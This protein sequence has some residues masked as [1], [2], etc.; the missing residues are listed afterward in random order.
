MK[1]IHVSL[2]PPCRAAGSGKYPTKARRRGIEFSPTSK[3][4]GRR[5]VHGAEPAARPTHKELVKAR[6]ATNGS[7]ST[8]C[9]YPIRGIDLVGRA[10]RVCGAVTYEEAKRWLKKIGGEMIEGKEQMR[11]TGSIVV[12]VKSARGQ[13]VQRRALFDDTLKGYER[14]LEV[15]R[16]FVRACEELK[17]ALACAALGAS[18]ASPCFVLSVNMLTSTG[19]ESLPRSM[20]VHMSNPPCAMAHGQ[21]DRPQR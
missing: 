1:T 15:R 7:P 20:L 9:V 3:R 17:I 4:I 21:T 11:G 2:R 14:E 19:I 5:A 10:A 8:R 12:S 18:T 16:A 6:G 13:I